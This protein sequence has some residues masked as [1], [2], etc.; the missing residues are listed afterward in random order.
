MSTMFDEAIADAKKLREIAEANAKQQLME[1]MLPSIRL[2]IE[3][4]IMGDEESEVTFEDLI[5]DPESIEVEEVPETATPGFNVSVDVAGDAH[6]AVSS[7]DV[8]NEEDI[9]IVEEEPAEEELMTLTPEAAYALASLIKGH[10][11]AAEKN[12]LFEK[13][14]VLK[15]KIRKF[16]NA[17]TA[18]GIKTENVTLREI[19]CKHYTQ[20]LKEIITLRSEVILTEGA[21]NKKIARSAFKDILKEMKKMS[22]RHARAL[23]DKLF[24]GDHTGKM[25][26]LD[27]VLSS[28]DLD[29]LGVEDEEEVNVDDLDVEV[30]LSTGEVEEPEFEVEDE[31]VELEE[32][33]LILTD[34]DFDV[35]GVDSEDVTVDDLDVEVM[36]G[37]PAEEEVE[38]EDEEVE[39]E[40]VYE[41]DEGMLRQELRRMRRLREQ[42]EG[43][44]NAI[45]SASWVEGEVVGD[46]VLDVDEDDLL[47]A[48]DDELGTVSAVAESRRR[49]RRSNAKRAARLRNGRNTRKSSVNE[50][51]RNGVLRKKVVG[52]QKTASALKNQLVEMN[53]FNA[54]LLYV[55][56]L[57]Q[58]RDLN[59]KQ[60]RAIVEALDSA[61]T[62]REAKL[63]Y[64]SLTKSLKKRSSRSGLNESKVAR[65]LGSSSRST[66][67]ASVSR[68]GNEVNRWA[69][70]AGINKDNK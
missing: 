42:G 40:E 4:E 58:N 12:S 56:K 35:L 28:D 60:Q 22:R 17:L 53:L 66:R 46:V 57:M 5:M 49:A 6:I 51:R 3:Q 65:T 63:L 39:L 54:K 15:H 7:G 31:E 9:E 11:P 55:N 32:L 30:L 14:Q 68:N 70:L 26:E 36:M 23:F 37:E 16:S 59:A 44:D 24:E 43:V 8:T 45:A 62:L 48:L 61:K 18:A 27:V 13:M 10:S 52:Y 69:V 2:M 47:N 19:A 38:V 50:S 20:L 64:K 1:A 29:V 25:N 33:D 34:D 67:S 41:I 21:E